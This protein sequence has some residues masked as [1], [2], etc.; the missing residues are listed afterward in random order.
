MPIQR[1]LRARHAPINVTKVVGRVNPSK[2]R[3]V[4]PST[5][6]R[7]QV[8]NPIRHVLQSSVKRGGSQKNVLAMI[9]KAKVKVG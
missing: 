1:G 6:L 3:S 4:E 8:R 2:E 9:G 5:T 7:N